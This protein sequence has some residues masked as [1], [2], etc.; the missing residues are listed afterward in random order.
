[1]TEREIVVTAPR[2]TGP[3]GIALIQEFEDCVL[4]A[5]QDGGGVWTIGW[6][7]TGPGIHRG[8]VWSQGMADERF[9]SDIFLREDQLRR[10][11]KTAPTTQNQFD[12][13]MSLMYNIGMEAF[14]RSTLLR[15]HLEGEYLMAASQ[16][17]RWNKDNGKT[18]RGL[19]RRRHR[20]QSLYLSP[21]QGL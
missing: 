15:L 21:K 3:K 17:P 1:M 12:A 14:R 2:R 19:T 9:A 13:M 8:L 4:E 5:Y 20:E 10:L 16:F 6:G 11:L 7:A 18:I